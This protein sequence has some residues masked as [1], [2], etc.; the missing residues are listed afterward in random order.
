MNID[1]FQPNSEEERQ[2]IDTY[3]S[4]SKATSKI[5]RSL[6]P[7]N[8]LAALREAKPSDTSLMSLYLWAMKQEDY[9][10]CA[11]AK[12]LIEEKGIPI[13]KWPS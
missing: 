12:S 1:D 4:L 9:E 13:T 3:S 11:V 6:L 5:I 8:R 10:T 2:F 7:E